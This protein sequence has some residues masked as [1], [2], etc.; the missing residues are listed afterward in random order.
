MNAN[1][2]KIA[3]LCG[4]DARDIL[5]NPTMLVSCLMPIGFML[6]YRY[7]MRRIGGDRRRRTEQLRNCLPEQIDRGQ[8]DKRGHE[9]RDIRKRD[10]VPHVFAVALTVI[11]ADERLA[12]VSHSLHEIL[13]DTD[14]IIDNG[15]A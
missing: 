7:M 1:T 4:K 11:C 5:Q 8:T 2:R 9:R 10:R 13:H 3:V 15:V 12:S 14:H 6:L